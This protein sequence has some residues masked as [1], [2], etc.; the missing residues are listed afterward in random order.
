MNPGPTTN[1]TSVAIMVH[2]QEQ[3]V[4]SIDCVV[5]VQQAAKTFKAPHFIQKIK[6]QSPWLTHEY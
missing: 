2:R 4:R 3:N 5:I 6:I 1:N